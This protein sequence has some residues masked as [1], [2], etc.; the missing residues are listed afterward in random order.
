MR[1]PCAAMP[2]TAAIMPNSRTPK[3]T[4]R[5]LGSTWKLG[6]SL[7][8]VLVEAVRSAAP[9][10]S[11]GTT[12]S[13]AFMTT[14][15]ALRVA[16]GLSV[17][18]TGIFFSQPSAS[19]GLMTRLN[20]AAELGI[21]LRVVV[22][23]R[24]PFGLGV[25]A[26]ARLRAPVFAGFVGNVEALVFGEAE[27]F[28]GG[29]GGVGA[30]GFAVDLVG[31]GLGAAVTDDGAHADER[32]LGG[33]GLGGEDGFLDGDEVVAVF[34]HLHVPVVGL[35]ALGHVFGVAE[36]G[37]AVERDQIVVIEH[38]QLAQAEGSGERG[39]FMADAFHQIAVA[40]EDVG[41]VVDRLL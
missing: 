22:E 14:W 15:P 24:V 27:V 3:K 39:G 16:T 1:P 6:E 40:A 20:S 23:L 34:D 37:G 8:M 12:F 5:P 17:G 18:K 30:E 19:S 7:K 36:F 31:A 11:S 32:R 28:L 9:P 2:L 35:E 13:M 41:V 33:L 25:L 21:G 4:L 10:N 29:L 26:A 38:D